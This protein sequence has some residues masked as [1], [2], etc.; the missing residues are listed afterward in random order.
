MEADEIISNIMGVWAWP[1]TL[2]DVRPL[3]EVHVQPFDLPPSSRKNIPSQMSKYNELK[4]LPCYMKYNVQL[5]LVVTGSWYHTITLHVVIV[6]SAV[7][8]ECLSRFLNVAVH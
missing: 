4:T 6:Q 8:P 1:Q 7:P 5:Y 3:T 2:K